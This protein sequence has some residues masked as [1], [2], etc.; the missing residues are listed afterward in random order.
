M[1]SSHEKLP[2]S[3]VDYAEVL[4]ETLAEAFTELDSKDL[5]SKLAEEVANDPQWK[6]AVSYSW[7]RYEL[8][9]GKQTWEGWWKKEKFHIMQIL[10]VVIEKLLRIK[11]KAQ[12]ERNMEAISTKLF[13]R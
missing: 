5:D 2:L 10:V 4:E 11:Q 3:Q 6:T 7:K 9:V 1:S 8:E 12:L 13:S